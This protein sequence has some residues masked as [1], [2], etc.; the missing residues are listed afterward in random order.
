MYKMKL[1][2]LIV[3]VFKFMLIN[4]HLSTLYTYIFQLQRYENVFILLLVFI[5]VV[6]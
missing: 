1:K 2:S 6:G 5:S 4:L 3:N